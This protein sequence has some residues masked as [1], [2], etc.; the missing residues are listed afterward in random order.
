MKMFFIYNQRVVCYEYLIQEGLDLCASK[1]HYREAK[2]KNKKFVL[3][4]EADNVLICCQSA[5]KGDVVKLPTCEFTLQS[6]IDVGHKIASKN[7]E[8]SQKIFR[9]GVPIG[10]ATA[11]IKQGCHVHL[12]NMKSDYIPSHTRQAVNGDNNGRLFKK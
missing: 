3:L 2:V 1:H 11:D 4:H 6:D 8:N 12:H 10:S 9:Y 7:I 5:M